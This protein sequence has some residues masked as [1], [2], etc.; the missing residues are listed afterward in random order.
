VSV[1][2]NPENARSRAALG[3][4]YL[5]SGETDQAIQE[6]QRAVEID[7]SDRSASYQLM[8]AYRKAGRHAEATEL[9]ERVRR[10]VDDSRQEELEKNRY[11]LV[12][13]DQVERR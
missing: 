12:R 11:R 4:L 1:E 9:M 2:T 3:Q 10:M 13:G 6:L 8:L 7:S 5:K